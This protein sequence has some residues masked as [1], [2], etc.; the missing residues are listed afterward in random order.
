MSLQLHSYAKINHFLHIVGK[1]S[2]GLHNIQSLL[3]KISLSDTMLFSKADKST[4][5]VKT[6]EGN[7]LEIID[8]IALKALRQV[9]KFV[10]KSLPLAIA[11]VK[12]IPMGA[13]MGGGSSN[14][15]STI[16]AANQLYNLNLTLADRLTI[17]TTIGA[18]VAFLVCPY[19][20]AVVSG[21]GDIV[22]QVPGQKRYLVA[23][24]PNVNINTGNAFSL[25]ELQ[26]NCK[27]YDFDYI[28]ANLTKISSN[29][30][31]KFI[32]VFKNP[33]INSNA[34]VRKIADFL[35]EQ[36][37]SIFAKQNIKVQMSGSGSTLFC[38]FATAEQANKLYKHLK[39]QNFLEKHFLF[40][41][42]SLNNL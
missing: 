35:Q 40:K 6:I 13:G 17:A 41:V 2:D 34:T 21:I 36:L 38:N 10:N 19:D 14:A 1:S 3:Q 39:Q 7:N 15:A 32:N 37:D 28:Q 33:I 29:T 25:A 12:N 9:E 23:I 11:I 16:L 30:A 24:T 31:Q 20:T 8:N 4:V 27:T 5:L 26:R 22:Q 18:D 42:A